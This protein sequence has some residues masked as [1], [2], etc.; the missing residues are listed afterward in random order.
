MLKTLVGESEFE[1]PTPLGPEP[2]FEACWILLKC[3][4]AK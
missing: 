2:D 3:G 4:D 1:P